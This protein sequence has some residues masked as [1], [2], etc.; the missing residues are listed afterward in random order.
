[1]CNI[2]FVKTYKP[3]VTDEEAL[4]LD[5]D[6]SMYI[7]AGHCHDDALE[8]AGIA[9]NKNPAVRFVRKYLPHC[10]EQDALEKF[11]I[12]LSYREEGQ[13]VLVSRQYADLCR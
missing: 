6:Y 10:S 9:M 3:E 5:V 1:M 11:R 2:Q 12:Y 13:S 8:F 4:R 7:D